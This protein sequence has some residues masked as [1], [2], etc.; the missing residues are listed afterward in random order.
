MHQLADSR[1]SF[2]WA[3]NVRKPLQQIDV[4]EKGVA[5][6]LGGTWEIYLGVI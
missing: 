2:D 3:N 5:E 4:I 6:S 1:P